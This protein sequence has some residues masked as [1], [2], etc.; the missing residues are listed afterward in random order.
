M[1]REK[2]TS[3]DR[4]ESEVLVMVSGMMVLTMMMAMMGGGAGDAGIG[5]SGGRC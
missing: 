1:R 2:Q 5:G 4:F 3:V